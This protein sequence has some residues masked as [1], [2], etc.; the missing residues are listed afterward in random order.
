MNTN[1]CCQSKMSRSPLKQIFFTLAPRILKVAK[2]RDIP[3]MRD[4]ITACI[5]EEESD[6]EDDGQT[7]LTVGKKGFYLYVCR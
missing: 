7:N 1:A 3:Q 5:D 2:K 6:D 4:L